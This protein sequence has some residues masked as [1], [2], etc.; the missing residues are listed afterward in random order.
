MTLSAI[1]IELG[2]LTLLFFFSGMIKPKWPLFF[3]NQPT[4]FLV[5]A[6]TMVMVMVTIT[7]YGEA[8]KHKNLAMPAGQA[9][10]AKQQSPVPVPSVPAAPAA[11]K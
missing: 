4:R 11:Q 3:L 7:T 9:A 5:M 6:I 1:A 10:I 2:L 8:V